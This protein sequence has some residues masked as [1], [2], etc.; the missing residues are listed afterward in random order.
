MLMS[1]KSEKTVE[2]WTFK[3][4][5]LRIYKNSLILLIILQGGIK[6]EEPCSIFL[7]SLHLIA[8]WAHL[9]SEK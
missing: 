1:E 9:T 5:N 2:L 6:A 4:L 7:M 3:E 8:H